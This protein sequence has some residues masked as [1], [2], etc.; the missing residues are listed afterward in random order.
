MTAD[1][2]WNPA[3]PTNQERTR[4]S[5]RAIRAHLMAWDP[6]TRLPATPA[7]AGRPTVRPGRRTPRATA[8]RTNDRTLVAEFAAIDDVPVPH[9]DGLATAGAVRRAAFRVVDVAG[10][11]ETADRSRVLSDGPG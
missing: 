4:E 11:D 1:D 3:D 8:H 7:P 9:N 10:V 2:P 5:Q 6:A